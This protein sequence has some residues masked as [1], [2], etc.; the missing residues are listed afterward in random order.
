MQQ[1]ST[2]IT[3]HTNRCDKTKLVVLIV[4]IEMVVYILTNK[5][6]LFS[7]NLSRCLA[8]F[9][10]ALFSTQTARSKNYDTVLLFG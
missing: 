7:F 9:V 3:D 8:V 6:D 1:Y 10:N 4:F 2:F 5:L